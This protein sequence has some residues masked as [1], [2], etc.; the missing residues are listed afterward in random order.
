MERLDLALMLLLIYLYL[1]K[2]Y[3]MTSFLENHIPKEK[4]CPSC[5]KHLRDKSFSFDDDL[6]LI[7]GFC[8]AIVFSTKENAITKAINNLYKSNK[9]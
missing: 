2:K 7:C 5:C 6:N 4:S 3:K 9:M 8:G 1:G